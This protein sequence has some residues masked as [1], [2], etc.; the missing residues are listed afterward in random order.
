LPAAWFDPVARGNTSIEGYNCGADVYWLAVNY[1]TGGEVANINFPHSSVDLV[2]F[3]EAPYDPALPYTMNVRIVAV[4]S[5]VG[6]LFPTPGAIVTAQNAAYVFAPAVSGPNP[7]N[8]DEPGY[9]DPVYFDR[10]NTNWAAQVSP[11]SIW[12]PGDNGFYGSRIGVYSLLNDTDLAIE[13][14]GVEQR[15]SVWNRQC[16]DVSSLITIEADGGYD[17]AT[18][19]QSGD[20][21]FSGVSV[22]GVDDSQEVR[23]D[24]REPREFQP[25]CSLGTCNSSGV[26]VA[27]PGPAP[28]TPVVTILPL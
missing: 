19:A 27:R 13:F 18:G 11:L 3:Q 23:C 17:P 21:R 16:S 4:H 1:C 6:A 15:L 25:A 20:R 9:W 14:C 8:R 28:G 2:S 5:E 26:C 22:L 7:F 10:D 12:N 24:V